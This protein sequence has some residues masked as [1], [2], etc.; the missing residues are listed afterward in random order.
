MVRGNVK[1]SVDT[2]NT[3]GVESGTYGESAQLARELLTCGYLYFGKPCPF[4]FAA[5]NE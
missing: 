4:F 3:E 5:E 2:F 1:D